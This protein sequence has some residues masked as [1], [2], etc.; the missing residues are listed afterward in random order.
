MTV[1]EQGTGAEVDPEEL[2]RLLLRLKEFL[3]KVRTA[4]R[5][6]LRAIGDDTIAEQRRILDGPLPRGVKKTGQHVEVRQRA[7]KSKKFRAIRV[8]DYADT[9]V[10][11]SGRSTG[12]RDGIK[13]GLKLRIVAGKTRQ[14]IEL[15]TTGPK[16]A[17]GYNR[18]KFW[19]KR[20]FRHRVFG[21]DT[22]VYQAGQPY[23][24][25]PALAGRDEMVRRAGE[26]L[27]DAASKE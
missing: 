1:A 15:K 26:I 7:G 9:K 21:G 18:A 4:A 3:P 24:R 2:K 22:Y 10:K 5:R 12:L 17:H 8:N 25:G 11:R 27:R 6:E 13:A 16:D 23:F 19:E 20:V 14:G